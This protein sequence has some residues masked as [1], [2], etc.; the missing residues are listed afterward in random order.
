VSVEGKIEISAPWPAD[1][2]ELGSEGAADV[3][4][5]REFERLLPHPIPAR[6]QAIRSEI[7]VVRN[8]A[9]PTQN[10]DFSGQYDRLLSDAARFHFRGWK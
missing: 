7:P 8:I 6:T 1:E 2:P 4:L 10:I 5:D 9:P 3:T